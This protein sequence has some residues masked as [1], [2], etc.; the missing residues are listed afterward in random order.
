MRMRLI[1]V[2]TE[3]VYVFVCVILLHASGVQLAACDR[4]SHHAGV[5][6]QQERVTGFVQGQRERLSRLHRVITAPTHTHW[7][8][9]YNPTC[10]FTTK[11]FLEHEYAH[12]LKPNNF[13]SVWVMSTL[14]HSLSTHTQQQGRDIRTHITCEKV[15]QSPQRLSTYRTYILYSICHLHAVLKVQ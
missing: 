3:G 9:Q 7:S 13:T 2:Q 14:T 5:E 8:H 10:T 6:G 15:R 4:H 12:S 11:H 1:S